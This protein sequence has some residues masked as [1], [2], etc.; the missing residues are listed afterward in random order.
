M[1]QRFRNLGAIA[2]SLLLSGSLA[3]S[4]AQAQGEAQTPPG[5]ASAT[6]KV[7]GTVLHYVRAGKG[8]PVILIHGFPQDWSEYRAI[9]PR[10]SQR[11]TVVA[12]DLRGIGG[13]AA[14]AG[15]YDAANMAEDV[16]RLAEVLKLERAY[17]VG[18]DL[19]G[20]VTYAYLRR[21]PQTLRGAMILDAPIPGIAGWDEAISG[22]GV[23]H[24]GFMQVPGLAEKLVPGRQV[25]YLGYFYDMGKFT[26]AERA[27]HLRSHAS[28]AQLHA[29]FEMYRALPDDAKFNAAQTASND[30]P[31]VFAAGEKSPFASLVPKFAEGFRA[32]GLSRVETATIPGAV[33]YVVADQPEAVVALIERYAGD[34]AHNK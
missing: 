1:M 23:W 11:F 18:H 30:V 28:R 3:L 24:V 19:G 15:G 34:P 26:A 4:Q 2:L 17:V 8:P 6:A 13:S 27:Y 33:H 5:F 20:I 25:D 14:A 12:V 29:A 21:Y 31:L 22:P 9:M 32:N 16:R 10:L 7:N